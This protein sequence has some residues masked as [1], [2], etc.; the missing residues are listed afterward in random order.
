[1]Q[2]SSAD[3]HGAVALFLAISWLQYLELRVDDL[4]HEFMPL[5][6]D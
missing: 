3:L 4:L 6:G 1:M 2:G 5:N